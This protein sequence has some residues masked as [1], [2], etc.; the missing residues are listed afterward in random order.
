MRRSASEICTRG[1]CSVFHKTLHDIAKIGYF[2]QSVQLCECTYAE[3]V[4]AAPA[5]Y[6]DHAPK[7]VFERAH[8][9]D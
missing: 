7:R 9:I 2:A 8:D 6:T 1:D 5:R 3:S 4:F